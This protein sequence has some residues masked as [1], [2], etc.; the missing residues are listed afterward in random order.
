MEAQGGPITWG[1]L[2]IMEVHKGPSACGPHIEVQMGSNTGGHLW[3]RGYG[4][5]HAGPIY[6]EAIAAAGE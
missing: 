1:P 3:K 5:A 6:M 4:P 2:I